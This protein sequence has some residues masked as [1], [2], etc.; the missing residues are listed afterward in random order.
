MAC[1]QGLRGAAAIAWILAR[2][3][4]SILEEGDRLMCLLLSYFRVTD[5][6][7]L[8]AVKGVCRC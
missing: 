1:S 5:H 8:L 6:Q 2:F 4:V 3:S 7:K